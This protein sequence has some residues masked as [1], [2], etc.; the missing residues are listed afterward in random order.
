MTPE[1]R[2]A[3]FAELYATIPDPK[4]KGLCVDTCTAIPLTVYEAR[5]LRKAGMPM[6]HAEDMVV[7][8]LAGEH[9]RCPAL[10]EG[11]CTVYDIRPLICRLYGAVEDLRCEHGCEPDEGFMATEDSHRLLEV[12]TNLGGGLR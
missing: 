11:R 10:V 9:P 4:C 1:Q 5:V 7:R 12:L 3:I 6:P 8:I 2:A